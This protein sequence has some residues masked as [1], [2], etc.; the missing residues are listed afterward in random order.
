MQEYQSE[1][2]CTKAQ[3]FLVSARPN[4]TGQFTNL[5][6]EKMNAKTSSRSAAFQSKKNALIAG[7]RKEAETMVSEGRAYV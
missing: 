7:A 4:M 1:I 2:V 3:I 5:F 6:A